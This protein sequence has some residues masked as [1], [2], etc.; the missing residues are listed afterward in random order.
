MGFLTR[1][2][3]FIL[4][5]ATLLLPGTGAALTL[6]EG[7]QVVTGQGRDVAIARSDESIA[8][9]AVSLA[10]APWL[11]SIDAYARETWLYY[12]PG[13][14]FGPTGI[15]A[16]T[17]D[18]QFFTYGF[19]ATQVLY[20]FGKTS[21]SVTAAKEGLR[22]REAGT[23]RARNRA[24]LEF[25]SAYF[26]LLE[27]GDVLKVAQEELTRYEAHRKDAEARFKSGV[28]TRNE[29][30][31]A[32]VMLADSKQRLLTA[33]NNRALRA[34]RINSLL[35][36]PLSDPVDPSEIVGS[37]L[38]SITLEEAWAAA[39]TD[40]P[41]IRDLD[42]R[43]RAKEASISSV[44]AEYLPTVYVSGGYEYSQNQYQL[45]EYNWTIIAGVNINLSAGGATGSRAAMARSEAWSLKLGREKHLDTVRLDV[46]SAYLE[47]E[48]SR[49]KIQVALTSVAQAEEN[50][51]L[52]RL[53]YREGV[54]TATEVLDAVALMTSAETNAWRA[55]YGLK[56]AEAALLY[57]MG[58]DLAGAYASGR[59][60]FGDPRSTTPPNSPQQ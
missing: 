29:V 34:S 41:D 18:D 40:N 46:Q 7:L 9:D 11:P 47:L 26:D 23:L 15:P 30:L 39:G 31:Q 36:R 21:S 20:D 8:R 14:K 43:I 28:V 38:G 17:S 60:S 10:R 50:L 53:R 1:T 13:V 12:Q 33:E 56:R 24:A 37:P 58:R 48:S 59:S 25:I 42:A 45:H 51:R 19:K 5:S 52:Q 2:I 55:N 44:Q 6:Q 57:S 22:A 27:A 3:Q 16:Y 4:L 35:L 54:G 49:Q 32:E